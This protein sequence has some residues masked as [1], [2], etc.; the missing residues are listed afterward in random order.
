MADDTCRVAVT[1]SHPDGPPF[2]RSDAVL[3]LPSWC[4]GDP[5]SAAA[6][7]LWGYAD[8]RHDYMVSATVIDDD[9]D[10]DDDKCGPGCR[11]GHPD[12][13]LGHLYC[14]GSNE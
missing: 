14:E 13:G 2:G 5:A 6:L 7:Y 3:T 9:D 10:D 11:S 12:F 1:Y 8:A 4:S